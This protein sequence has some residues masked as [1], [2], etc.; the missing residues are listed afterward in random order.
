[1]RKN[2]R[3]QEGRERVPDHCKQDENRTKWNRGERCQTVLRKKEQSPASLRHAICEEL[4]T[5]ANTV[6]C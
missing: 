4:I 6:T 3:G 5:D 1:M 2:W